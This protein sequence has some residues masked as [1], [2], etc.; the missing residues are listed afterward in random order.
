[1]ISWWFS[2]FSF[3]KNVWQTSF[4]QLTSFISSRVVPTKILSIIRRWV[5]EILSQRIEAILFHCFAKFFIVPSLLWIVNRIFFHFAL[6]FLLLLHI[7]DSSG[8]T[9]ASRP[10]FYHLTLNSC[11]TE[12]LAVNVTSTFQSG[13]IF[14]GYCGL[15]IFFE[16]NLSNVLSFYT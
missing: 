14:P 7:S 5:G 1:M 10:V 8:Q 13:Q 3:S 11:V 15:L 4:F 6:K 12:S 16:Q 9:W 2:V